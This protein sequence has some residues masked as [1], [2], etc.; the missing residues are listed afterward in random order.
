MDGQDV[1][2]Q[3]TQF[4]L[5][6]IFFS[7]TNYLISNILFDNVCILQISI[8]LILLIDV[9]PLVPATESYLESLRE[10]SRGR[11]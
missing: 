9:K 2:D 6:D 1:Q 10:Q 4:A 3:I 7:L 11:V 8:L 5:F